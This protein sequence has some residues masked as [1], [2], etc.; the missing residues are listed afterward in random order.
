MTEQVIQEVLQA[1]TPTFN[2]RDDSPPPPTHEGQSQNDATVDDNARGSDIRL[3]NVSNARQM[4]LHMHKKPGR[5]QEKSHLNIVLSSNHSIL[6]RRDCIGYIKS[7]I[8]S[9]YVI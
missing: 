3:R 4:S 2:T 6:Y 1:E 7:I 9:I 5:G 8:N